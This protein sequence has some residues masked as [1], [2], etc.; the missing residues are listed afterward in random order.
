MLDLEIKTIEIHS[1]PFPGCT[2]EYFIQSI[3]GGYRITK[4][5]GSGMPN[6]IPNDYQIDLDIIQADKMFTKIMKFAKTEDWDNKDEKHENPYSEWYV[7][8][9]YINGETEEILN[10]DSKYKSIEPII[11]IIKSTIRWIL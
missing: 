10:Y 1:I 8:I 11:K 6:G 4:T 7:N 5:S 9:T 2:E 3:E